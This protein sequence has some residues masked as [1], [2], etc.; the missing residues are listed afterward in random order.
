M[1]PLHV[2]DFPFLIGG[3]KRMGAVAVHVSE[4]IGRASIRVEDRRLVER[5]GAEGEEV[6]L[7]VRVLQMRGRVAL[8]GVDEGGEEDRVADEED[9]RVV[10]HHV[11]VALFRVELEGKASRVA[12]RVRGARLPAHRAEPRRHIRL[13]AHALKEAR[14]AEA[15]HIVRHFEGSKGSTAS[16]IYTRNAQQIR[17]IHSMYSSR[18]YLAWTTRSG[19]LSLSKAARWSMRV[20]SCRRRGPLAPARRE[21]VSESMGA[22]FEVVATGGLLLKLAALVCAIIRIVRIVKKE[23]RRVPC[24][25]RGRGFTRPVR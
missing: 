10:A 11:P 17:Q 16:N 14:P 19:I 22:P 7:G 9:R 4:A 21:A 24:M 6:P 23:Q 3:L 20:K 1:L 13:L 12:C 5:L 25:Y 15:G 2:E 8:L 18:L